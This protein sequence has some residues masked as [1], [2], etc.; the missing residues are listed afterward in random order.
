M[1]TATGVKKKKVGEWIKSRDAREK[2]VILAKCAHPYGHDRVTPD[3]IQADLDE[4][5]ATMGVDY[6]DM[7][8][9]HRDDPKVPVGPIVEKLNALAK[10]GRIGAFGGSNWSTARIQAANDYA[11]EHGLT[12]FAIS[13][14]NF[15][16]AEQVEEP[17]TDCVTISGPDG[18]PAREYY[19]A[20]KDDIALFTWSSLAGGFFSDRFT[21]EN[22]E[23]LSKIGYFEGLVKKCYAYEQNWQRLDRVRELAKAKS[24][25]VPQVALAYVMSQPMNIFALV[26]CATKE[27][28]EANNA[29]LDVVLTAQEMAWLDL[30]ADSP[31]S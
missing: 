27:Q 9:L 2:L 1:L 21:R 12:P 25:A 16:L 3:D 30:R 23:E 26:F 22:M 19:T 31:S 24:L 10:E 6:F 13:S 18:A 4:S 17:W 20:H 5:M 28:F 29:A 15:S 8:V 11:R 14:P 7:L